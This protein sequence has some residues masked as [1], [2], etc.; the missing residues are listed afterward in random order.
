MHFPQVSCDNH[1]GFRM[2]CPLPQDHNQRSFVMDKQSADTTKPVTLNLNGPFYAGFR[3]KKRDGNPAYNAEDQACIERT[4]TK[5]FALS[6]DPSNPIVLLGKI[7]SGKTKAFLGIAALAFDNGYDI[8]VIFTKPTTA[9]AKQ[10]CKRVTKEF[11]EFIEGDQAKVYDILE[12]PERLTQFELNQKLMFVV[13]KQTNNLDRLSEALLETYPQLANRHILIIDDEAD[14]ASIGYV[15][16]KDQGLQ[17]RTIAGQIDE[18]RSKL[19]N[20]SFLQVTATP[21]SLYLQPEGSPLPS[22]ALAPVRP[23]STELVPVHADYVGGNFYFEESQLQDNP[24]SFV[25]RPIQESE[26]SVLESEDRRKFKVEDCLV[27]DRVFGL[28]SALV[29]FITAACLRRIQDEQMQRRPKRFA[30]LFHTAASRASH[31]WQES[32]ILRFDEKLQ[33]EA[34]TNSEILKNLVQT[35]YEDLTQSLVAANQVPP[36]F[37]EVHKRVLQALTGGELMITKVNS[38][39]QVSSLLD[40]EG[41]LRLRTPL[42]IFIGGQI[43]DR[44]ITIANLIGFYYGRNPARFQQDTVLQHSRMYGFRPLED[45]AVTRFYTSPRIYSAMKRM[46]EADAALRDRIEVSGGDQSV[47]FI[48]LDTSGQIVP[49]GNQKILASNITTLRPSRRILPVGFQTDFKTRLH[50]ITQEID[51]LLKSYG[52]YPQ[53]GEAPPPFEISLEQACT[54]IDKV[55]PTFVDFA[56]GY[57]D[58]WDAAEYKAIL[59]HLSTN[60]QDARLKGKVLLLVRTGRNLNRELKSTSH[61]EFADAPDT[62]RTEGMVARSAAVNV[63]LLMMIR[64]NGAAAQGWRDC[65]FWW[66]VIVTPANTRTTLFAHAR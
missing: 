52:P 54:I 51:N 27:S 33:E 45:R 20:A 43:L 14:N 23:Q 36:A 39:A 21:Y 15:Q 3:A 26:L 41:Q 57:E 37:S 13:K 24:A 28:R 25:F 18:L 40:D 46:H 1:D 10:T 61:A 59:Q 9:L 11:S 55:D 64:Q 5:L 6:S 49:C 30:F 34:R 60:S 62:T 42:N 38:E 31:A 7:Q 22:I 17:L 2:T 44:G 16:D 4:V 35:A 63:P 53:D 66:P 8:A 47:Y 29:S 48:E 58:R 50:P 65:P 56:P 12:L 19:P 32:V